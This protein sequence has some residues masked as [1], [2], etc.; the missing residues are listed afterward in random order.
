MS[1]PTPNQADQT[2]V[3]SESRDAAAAFVGTLNFMIGRIG[4]D[5]MS[6]LERTQSPQEFVQAW[7]ARNARYYDA[8]AKYIVERFD[9]ALSDG[10]TAKRDT[11]IEQYF[12]AIKQKGELSARE[13]LSRG[14]GKQACERA[15]AL[16]E[17]GAADITSDAPMFDE[18]EALVEWAQQH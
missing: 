4:R 16:I 15:V 6:T 1:L 8:H 13:W 7:Q 11:V 12:T 18:L 14:E 9:E 5:C 17:S 10:G 2:S 3:E